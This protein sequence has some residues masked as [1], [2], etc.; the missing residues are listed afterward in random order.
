MCKQS[1]ELWTN[2]VS[3][4]EE[5]VGVL[6]NTFDTACELIELFHGGTRSR[7]IETVTNDKRTREAQHSPAV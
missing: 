3:I 7:G 6:L 5:L 4:G 2:L 1:V